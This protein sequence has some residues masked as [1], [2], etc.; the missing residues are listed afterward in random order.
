MSGGAF[1]SLEN[2][3]TFPPSVG[4]FIVADPNLIDRHA[5]VAKWHML[6]LFQVPTFQSYISFIHDF[7]HHSCRE[8]IQ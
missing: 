3:E 7:D 8:M 2:G 5:R 6:N 1:S 4:M